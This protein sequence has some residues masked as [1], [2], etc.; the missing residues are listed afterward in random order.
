MSGLS[1]LLR[2]DAGHHA[3]AVRQQS[4]EP[5]VQELI[6][7]KR[8]CAIAV[9]L[10]DG[11][12]VLVR[13]IRSADASALVAFHDGLSAASVQNRFFASHPH[14]SED[15]ARRFVEVDGDRRVALVALTG[16][17]IVGVA[18]YEGLPAARSVE[19]AFVVADA[20]QRQGLGTRLFFL[21]AVLARTH[22]YAR[23]TAQVLA[24]NHRMLEIFLH[25]GL[26][27]ETHR[28]G[29][30]VEIRIALDGVLDEGTAD[31]MS[32]D[33]EI[34]TG[35]VVEKPADP[36]CCVRHARTDPLGRKLA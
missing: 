17:R 22:G 25:C 7:E 3:G 23:L 20:F 18:R 8:H 24:T 26:P 30:I 5:G 36:D 21:L 28:E 31:E 33:I 19:I 9:Q 2:A 34:A 14:L 4:V 12:T 1:A 27:L 29:E 10:R 16:D 32:Q 15:E 11:E 13:P 6:S 35:G